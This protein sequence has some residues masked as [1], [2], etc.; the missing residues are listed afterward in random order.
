M[1]SSASPALG[2]WACQALP[3]SALYWKVLNKA[4]ASSRCIF[5]WEWRKCCCPTPP[6]SKRV[7]RKNSGAK[8]AA[9]EV[10]MTRGQS[11]S[12]KEKDTIYLRPSPPLSP[13]NCPHLARL[14]C[15]CSTEVTIK[16][17]PGCSFH[18]QSPTGLL[19]PT[20][21]GVFFLLQQIVKN[22]SS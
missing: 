12:R 18:K 7:V 5:L 10:T 6:V 15:G 14:Q 8:F 19:L 9:P 1:L 22:P 4:C 21:G 16:T 20:G 2:H 17:L 3:R 13:Q 11:S